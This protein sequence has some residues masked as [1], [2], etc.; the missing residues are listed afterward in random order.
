MYFLID[1]T[2][3]YCSAEKVFAPHLRK[4]P[5]ITLSNNDGAIVAV[6]PIAK[7][8]G[9]KKFVPFFQVRDLV[10]KHNVVVTSSN[11]ELY[12]SLSNKMMDTIARFA[13]DVHI[14]SID[15]LFARFDKPLNHES[16]LSLG[17]EI[18]KTVWKEVRLPVGAGGGPT[19]TLAKAASHAAKRIEGYR[20]VAV[21]SSDEERVAILKQMA[22]TDVWGIGSRLGKK[23]E[24]M[25][26]HSAYELSKKSPTYMRKQFSILVEN[27]IRE[28]NGEV[29][30][31]WD[32]VRPDKQQIYSTRTFGER[33]TS[34]NELHRALVGHCEAAMAKLRKQNSL[35]GAMTVFASNSP[36]D[37]T[38]FYRKSAYHQFAVPTLDTRVAS[39][40]IKAL[41]DKIFKPGVCFY[42]CGVGLLD[43]R[44]QTR[45][46]GDLFEPSQDNAGLMH[47]VDA[48]NGRYG[49][50]SMQ[51]ASK[52]FSKKH[53]M[54][55]D[56]LS[57]R[58]TTRWSDIPTIVC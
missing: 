24:F 23:L 7:R 58:A 45:Y 3:F 43:I 41:I 1:A 37:D 57:K 2:S 29:R 22:V 54:R 25:G 15:E 48:I 46:Q 39:N 51:I 30:I 6:C 44:P 8:L 21:I 9:I 27:T 52:G 5:T 33:V 32:D 13:D 17:L 35:A 55:R 16:W 40:A 4:R 34:S 31:A 11:Y 10:N 12:Q 36:H 20:G 49:K 47:V 19:P 50:S 26:I 14:Y 28:L 56:Y 38:A 42:K 53:A 18:R